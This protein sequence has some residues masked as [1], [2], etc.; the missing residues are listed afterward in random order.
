MKYTPA[1]GTAIRTINGNHQIVAGPGSGKSATLSARCVK[2]LMQSGVSPENI[3]AI[4]Y[5]ED[6]ANS[7]RQ[8]VHALAAEKLPDTTGVSAMFVGTFHAFCLSLLQ[9]D[10]FRYRNY[11][12]LSEVQ[13][14]LLVS[15]YPN[16]SGLT[17]ARWVKGSQ[18]GQPLT[19]DPRDIGQYLEALNTVREERLD[20]A[21]LPDGLREALGRWNRL[22][23][24]KHLLD[25]SRL[26]DEVLRAL[27]DTHD[28]EHLRLQQRLAA[29]VQYL[30][31]DESQDLSVAMSALVNRIHRLGA[32]VCMVA[33]DD[34]TVN[35][36]RGASPKHFLDFPKNYPDAHSHVLA[37]NFRSTVGVVETARTVIEGNGGRIPKDI[38]SA[39]HQQ[40]QRGDLLALGFKTPEEEAGWIARKMAELHG[41]PWRDKPDG[42][43]RGLAWS[44]MAV[45]LRSVRKDAAPIV[46]ALKAAG[47]PVVA[48]GMTGLFEPPEAEAVAVSFEYLAGAVDERAIREAWHRSE[49][50]LTDTELSAGIAHLDAVKTWDDAAQGVCC[51]QSVYLKLLGA[52][53][54]HEERVPP[55]SAGEPR[56]GAV[57][58]NLGRM[59]RA[60]ADYQSICFR[61]LTLRKF[62]EFAAW[63]RAEAPSAYEEVGDNSARVTPDAVQLQTVHRSKG[64]EF[65]AAWVPALQE[66]RFPSLVK[67][68][69]STRWHLIPRRLVADAQ[70]YDGGVEHERRLFYV[71]ITRAAKYLYC[72]WSPSSEQERLRKPSRFLTELTQSDYVLTCEPRS[73]DPRSAPAK[74]L[75]PK[76]RT[77]AISI[78]V[79]FSALK[80]WYGCQ[81]SFALRYL[82]GFEPP[83]VEELGFGRSF[84]DAQSEIRQR[85]LDGEVLTES[86]IDRIVTQHFHLPFASAKTRDRLHEKARRCMRRWVRERGHTLKDVR[87]VEMEVEVTIGNMTVKG[88]IDVL[89]V[90]I[91]GEAMIGETKTAEDALPNDTLRFQQYTYHLGLTAWDGHGAD[92]LETEYPTAEGAG[93]RRLEQVDAEETEATKRKLLQAARSI[94]RHDLPRLPMWCSTCE[95]CDHR[96]ICPTKALKNSG[97]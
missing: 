97:A 9:G 20:P 49:L 2:C 12:V 56:G 91:T 90:I 82:Y 75:A 19:A 85:A 15:R 62:A 29:R 58:Y 79:P 60:I 22:L 59:S 89:K 31:V 46:A 77:E 16:N 17:C 8:R 81:Y 96:D 30:M 66:G 39:S 51:L 86:Q 74:K 53:G 55:T 65:A 68:W 47:I 23:D 48:Q 18:A 33:D 84:H 25:Y 14:R 83:L 7:L 45:L 54:L 52:M 21:R 6:A 69:G 70:R 43:E 26:F 71:A 4:T 63:L 40:W 38:R 93:M 32:Q 87:M 1:Q 61:T 41:R 88:R 95:K 50:G 73:A 78:T 80:Y 72:T 36:W 64:L 10:L 35:A 11:S 37:E 5:N 42:P 3:V 27:D 76:P 44:D 57:M 92:L 94:E 13:A 34:Q 28:P 67:S 24:R